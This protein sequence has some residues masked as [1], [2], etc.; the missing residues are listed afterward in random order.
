MQQGPIP[1][2]GGAKAVYEE[3]RNEGFSHLDAMK[4]LK[5]AAVSALG[6]TG[7][8]A[9]EDYGEEQQNQPYSPSGGRHTSFAP[10]WKHGR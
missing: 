8:H 2:S 6:M 7:V 1:L 10:P 3:L 5:G 9:G 4:L